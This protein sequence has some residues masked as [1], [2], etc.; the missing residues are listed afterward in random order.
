MKPYGQKPDKRRWKIHSADCCSIC[1]NDEWKNS[2]KRKRRDTSDI[3]EVL[4]SEEI[5]PLDEAELTAK[6]VL[7]DVEDKQLFEASC[8][9]FE[10]KA[11]ALDP[12]EA[13]EKLSHILMRKYT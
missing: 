5:D 8:N 13:L 11:L 2:K 9:S 10:E 1:S 3:D 7:P 12:D 6:V 4:T